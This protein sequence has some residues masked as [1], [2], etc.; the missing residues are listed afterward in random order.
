MKKTIIMLLA[1][2]MLALTACGGSAAEPAEPAETKAANSPEAQ[3]SMQPEPE[4]PEQGEIYLYGEE[5]SNERLLAIELEL[6]QGYYED[7]MRHLFIEYGYANAQ[8]LNLWLRAEDDEILED[9]YQKSAG[10][11]GHSKYTFD[12]FRS[13]KETCPETVFHGTDVDRLAQTGFSGQ[14]LDYL[15]E[16]GLQ[17][18]EEY[19]LAVQ[20]MTQADEYY[21][22]GRTDAIAAARYR[23]RMMAENFIR[24]RD[25]IPGED[26]MGIYGAAHVRPGDNTYLGGE[27]E[28]MADMLIEAYGETLHTDDLTQ[29]PLRTDTLMVNGKEYQA[30]YYGEVDISDW[31]EDYVSR[32]FWRLEDAGSD[33]DGLEPTGWLPESNYP[34]EIETGQ[35]FVIKYHRADGGSE[36]RVLRCGEERFIDPNGGDQGLVTHELAVP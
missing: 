16:N 9:F 10:T 23:E 14:Y 30:S 34:M 24:E 5:H 19:A 4:S 8:L 29:R 2:A 26:I 32:E 6:W 18:S 13:I 36:Q 1:A 28:N 3:A 21:R 7:G 35:A 12:W 20:G 27:G 25:T 31:S 17:D 33:F 15:E 11:Q 22:L